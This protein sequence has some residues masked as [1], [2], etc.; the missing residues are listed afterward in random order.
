MTCPSLSRGRST[1]SGVRAALAERVRL[2]QRSEKDLLLRDLLRLAINARRLTDDAAGASYINIEGTVPRLSGAGR[3]PD[4]GPAVSIPFAV[5]G[6][7]KKNHM[8][9]RVRAGTRTRTG[10]PA[11]TA[12]DNP[13]QAAGD[14]LDDFCSA[15]EHVTS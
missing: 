12:A 2:V 4:H 6:G 11:V 10:I 5:R 13:E 7:I 14:L 8:P 9:A 1:L 3:Y 15:H